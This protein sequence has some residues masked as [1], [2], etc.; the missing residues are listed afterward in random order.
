MELQIFDCE[1]GSIEWFACRMG[2]PTASEAQT[3]MAQAG[4]RGGQKE[5]KG[6]RTYMLKLIGERMT[7]KPTE[8]FEDFH[9]A[10]GRTMEPEARAWYEMVTGS[11]LQRVGFMRRGDFGASSDSLVGDDGLLEI[12][13]KLP[14]LQLECLLD[15]VVPD[16]HKAQIQWQIW[17]ADR[18][19]CDFVS[20][21]PGL[22]GL[23]VRVARDDIYVAKMAKMA[24]E[25]MAELRATQRLFEAMA[26]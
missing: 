19:W 14:H 18:A 9:T 8:H 4:P 25:F 2:I 21:W 10:R 13:T 5:L 12:K 15:G 20:Y 3:I 16:E 24:E 22:P 17:V 6:R 11:T 7:G 23:K 26:A 1:Q